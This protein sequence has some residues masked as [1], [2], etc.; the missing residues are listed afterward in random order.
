MTGLLI[1]GGAGPGK[2][3]LADCRGVADVVAAADS[4]LESALRAG[5]TPDYVVGDMDSLS[6]PRLL[7]RFPKEKKR[8]LPADKD[9]TDT[10]YGLG[11]LQE[12]GCTDVV[13]AGG[14]GGRFDHALAIAMLFERERP[15]RRWITEKEDIR[16][17]D[18]ELE[19]SGRRGDIL[20]LFPVGGTAAD[21][22]SEG[23]RWPLDGLRF[24]RGY[25]GISN[26]ITGE[27]VKIRIGKG[28]LLMVLHATES[29][30]A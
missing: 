4:G 20:S 5:I 28:K 30:N 21:M 1:I 18:G 25:G 7:D 29:S 26:R 16:L 23:L 2:E 13:I 15:P 27:K 11:F 9:L 6:D 14:G 17:I 19:F 22:S 8:I 12:M 3:I 24:E 10:E